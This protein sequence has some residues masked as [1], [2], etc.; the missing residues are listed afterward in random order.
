MVYPQPSDA[1]VSRYVIT[2]DQA[3]TCAQGGCVVSPGGPRFS[4]REYT[5]E[6][7]PLS[8][9]YTFTVR[10]DNCEMDDNFQSG[11]ES[12]GLVLSLQREL[13]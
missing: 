4:Q 10:A 12:D 7:L 5:L 13:L 9:D 8:Q 3:S 11:M 2:S 6:N 1:A